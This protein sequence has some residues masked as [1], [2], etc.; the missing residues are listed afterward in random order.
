MKENPGENPDITGTIM[1]VLDKL[2]EAYAR[3]DLA[4]ILACYSGTPRA[5][6]SGPD[7]VVTNRRDLETAIRRDLA[8]AEKISVT[9]SGARVSVRGDVA[10]MMG[11]CQFRVVVNRNLQVLDGRM[12]VVFVMENGKWLIA[13][14]HFAVPSGDQR[15]GESYPGST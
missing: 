9:F 5:F 15:A 10:W 4:G 11:S 12:S 2:T 1:A 3:K 6:G 8:Q 14:S 13:Q 7:E